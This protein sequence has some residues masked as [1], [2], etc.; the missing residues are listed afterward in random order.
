[1]TNWQINHRHNNERIRE[2]LE[3]VLRDYPVNEVFYANMLARRIGKVRGREMCA[4][5]IG[6]FL[7]ERD[8]VQKVK[9]GIW[10]RVVV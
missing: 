2:V 7:K 3:K 9:S 5:T 8:D 10:R 6:L 1:M 4:H